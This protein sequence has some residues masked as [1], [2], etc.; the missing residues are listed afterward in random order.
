MDPRTYLKAIVGGLSA[1]LGVL[2]L[3]LNDN[4]VT[5]Q[6]WVGVAQATL[7]TVAAVYNIP[8]TGPVAFNTKVTDP[9]K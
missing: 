1:G 2:F 6:E 9:V 5:G 8:N 4:V 7:V 3:A